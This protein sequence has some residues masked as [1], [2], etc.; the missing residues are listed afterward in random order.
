[1]FAVMETFCPKDAEPED[2]FEFYI[3]TVEFELLKVRFDFSVRY[4]AFLTPSHPF[5]AQNQCLRKVGTVADRSH[6]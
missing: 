1:M 5:P 3:G 6:I 2:S 4:A